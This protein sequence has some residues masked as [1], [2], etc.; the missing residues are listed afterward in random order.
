MC[1]LLAASCQHPAT[2]MES[3]DDEI[4]VDVNE[5]DH[6]LELLHDNVKKYGT[7]YNKVAPGIQ[8]AGVL[9]WPTQ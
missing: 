8:I 1:E 2:K 4:L 5:S 9:R 3:I 6:R 7:A